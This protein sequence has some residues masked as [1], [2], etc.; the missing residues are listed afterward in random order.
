MRYKKIYII[1]V[2]VCDSAEHQFLILLYFQRQFL[3]KNLDSD[4]QKYSIVLVLEPK[5]GRKIPI[6]S[7]LSSLFALFICCQLF[8]FVLWSEKS[9]RISSAFWSLG[10]NMVFQFLIR[11]LRT[12]SACLRPL[13]KLCMS[14]LEGLNYIPWKFQQNWPSSFRAIGGESHLYPFCQKTLFFAW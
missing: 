3:R 13:L 4:L 5:G 7:Q 10:R 8:A 9:R 11:K 12:G 6:G 14:K 2:C 1:S